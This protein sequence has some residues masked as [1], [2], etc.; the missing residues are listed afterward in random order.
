MS[1]NLCFEIAPCQQGQCPRGKV[2]GDKNQCIT[3]GKDVWERVCSGHHPPLSPAA[4]QSQDSKWSC[5][6]CTYLNFQHLS[7]CEMC[8]FPRDNTAEEKKSGGGGDQ[9]PFDFSVMSYNLSWA[10]QTNILAGT[11]IAFVQACR[12]A[13]NNSTECTTL[14]AKWLK[15]MK[16]HPSLIG[17]QES[18][19][20][21]TDNFINALGDYTIYESEETN[22]AKVVI[23]ADTDL[24][25]G[26][27]IHGTGWEEGRPRIAVYFK[28][29]NIL[30]IC[31][32]FPHGWD[33]SMYTE[34][35]DI[36]SETLGKILL[37][38]NIG[39]KSLNIFFMGDF[40]DHTNQLIGEHSRNKYINFLNRR[41]YVDDGKNPYP[42]TCC[43][44][45][46]YYKSDYILSSK[47]PV[48]FGRIN[49][50]V[51]GR[52]RNQTRVSPIG[53]D[54]DPVIAFYG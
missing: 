37:N 29:F 41:L 52:K 34:Q 44:P 32:H 18:V 50:D 6:Q 35:L 24:G 11:E 17:I 43:Y 20:G 47:K 51:G 7:K 46:Y 22:Y 25:T 23:A 4:P 33:T 53:S 8:H 5:A 19:T 54:H 42:N 27:I 48:Y 36:Y 49:N 26:V 10:T 9:L 12:N 28:K 16:V 40:N 13:Y 38:M 1:K 31:N 21:P 39:L 2:C 14:M 3:V 45:Y 15:N 30:A